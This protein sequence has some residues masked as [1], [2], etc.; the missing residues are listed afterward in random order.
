MLCRHVLFSY[1]FTCFRFSVVVDVSSTDTLRKSSDDYSRK[2]LSGKFYF[3]LIK[4][5]HRLRCGRHASTVL[6]SY[7][8]FT[9]YHSF[10]LYIYVSKT[11][12]FT[13]MSR[14]CTSRICIA[15]LIEA[16]EDEVSS[17][18]PDRHRMFRK[19]SSKSIMLISRSY[20]CKV[21]TQKTSTRNLKDKIQ[22]INVTQ[23]TKRLQFVCCHL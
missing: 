12:I 17:S 23:F 16:E 6:R 9:L 10:F 18:L 21:P 7:F 15:D 11:H 14:F 2:H 8:N 20:I 5:I 19:A 4:G 1:R 22:L 3:S 13:I